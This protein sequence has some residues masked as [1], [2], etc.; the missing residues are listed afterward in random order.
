MNLISL[1]CFLIFSLCFRLSWC[2]LIVCIDSFV[3]CVICL[4]DS[5]LVSVLRMLCLCGVNWFSGD[6]V[7]F[8]WIMCVVSFLLKNVCLVSMVLIVWM[9]LFVGEFFSR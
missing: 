9:I 8:V 7:V 3:C 5:F 2:V 1:V 6:V 4:F